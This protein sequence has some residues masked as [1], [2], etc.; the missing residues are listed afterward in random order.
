MSNDCEADRIVAE[1][2]QMGWEDIYDNESTKL[3]QAFPDPTKV[4][5][6][7]Y[8]HEWVMKN[9]SEG[10]NVLEVGCGVGL[11]AYMMIMGKRQYL[12]VDV[13][14]FAVEHCKNVIPSGTFVQGFAEKLNLEPDQFDVVVSNQVLEH[15]KTPEIALAEMVRVL[16]VGGKLIVTVPIEKKLNDK[17][18]VQ[19][20][21][22][23]QIIQM[24]EKF[25]KDFKIYYL[26]KYVRMNIAYEPEE[27][28][29]FGIILVKEGK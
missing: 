19:H 27:K 23:Y 25:S 11:L 5:A 17:T 9:T 13:S 18:H 14:K 28:N 10:N 21:D 7:Y 3:S 2:K 15:L 8:I 26:N 29:V 6:H 22:I 12:G 1:L 20:W 16:K 24:F 4:D